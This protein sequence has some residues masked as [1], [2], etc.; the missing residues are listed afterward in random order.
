MTTPVDLPSVG[1]LPHRYPFLFVDRIVEFEPGRRIVGIKRV[2]WDEPH[3][4][5]QPE[6][7]PVMPPTLLMEAVAQVGAVLVLAMPEHRHKLAFFLSID[8]IRMRHLVR[9]G[10]TMVI[11]A[12]VQ[13]LRATMGRMSGIIKVDDKTIA[14][15]VVTFALVESGPALG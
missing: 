13:K 15:G 14:T 2:S 1:L 4:S 12:T 9:A 5:V 7:P 8:R 10:D 11:E 6:G 3:M